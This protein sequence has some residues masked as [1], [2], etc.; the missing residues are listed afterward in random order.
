MR[1]PESNAVETQR[2]L[3]LTCVSSGVPSPTVTF[4]HKSSEVQLD[5]RVIQQGHFLIITSAEEG[6]N[7]EYYC[8]AE[9]VAGAVQSEPARLVIFSK[10]HLQLVM[11]RLLFDN[12]LIMKLNRI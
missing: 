9:N 4:F 11:Y 1:P 8:T 3:S 6:D 7:G 5:S 2:A 12:I 10:L